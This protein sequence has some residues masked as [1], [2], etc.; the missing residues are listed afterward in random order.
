MSVLAYGTRDPNDIC[1]YPR[2]GKVMIRGV[3]LVGRL[4]RLDYWEGED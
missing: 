3:G 2:S 4:E 1:F